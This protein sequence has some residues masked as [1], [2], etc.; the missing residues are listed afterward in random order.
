[1][2]KLGTKPPKENLPQQPP[3]FT[4]ADKL[5]FDETKERFEFEM[6]SAGVMH[7]KSVLFLTLISIFAAFLTTLVSRLLDHGRGSLIAIGSLCIIVTCLATLIFATIIL[8]RSALARYKILGLPSE[9]AQHLWQLKQIYKGF[10][11]DEIT[12][13][14]HFNYDLLERWIEVVDQCSKQNEQKAKELERVSHLLS[15][16]IPISFIGLILVLIQSN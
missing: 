1:M 16:T 15:I 2:D 10:S 14:A 6:K 3:A 8:G 12:V 9:W 5:L 11:N 4:L 13:L 7:S